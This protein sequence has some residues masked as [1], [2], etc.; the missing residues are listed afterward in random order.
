M[1][2]SPD[3]TV[4]QFQGLE[5][6]LSDYYKLIILNVGFYLFYIDLIDINRYLKYITCVNCWAKDKEREVF[7]V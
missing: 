2:F 3:D 5:S 1:S 6:F 4:K 7:Q